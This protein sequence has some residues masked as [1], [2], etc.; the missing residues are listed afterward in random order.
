MTKNDLYGILHRAMKYSSYFKRSSAEELLRRFMKS[1]YSVVDFGC[2][3]GE[4]LK[5][6]RDMGADVVQGVETEFD[7]IEPIDVPV[8]YGDLASDEIDLGRKFDI[9]ICVEVAEHLPSESAKGLVDNIARH[10]DMVIF[11]AA[12]PGQGGVF[13]VNEQ[14]PKYWSD[15]FAAK[16]F[17]CYDI[18]EE[19]WENT[20]VESWYRQ[21]LLI[22]ERRG[23]HKVPEEFRDKVT[24]SPKHIIHPDIFKLYAPQ[25]SHILLYENGVGS[26]K[27]VIIPFQA[28]CDDEESESPN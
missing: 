14:P 5:V 7:S 28:V 24:E 4:W 16:G 23:T 26:F 22:F 8:F 3:T 10:C 11:S 12:V 21:N 9:G 15:L 27:P 18:R 17:V 13:H 6:A 19:F 25:D 1:N 20:K 2:G